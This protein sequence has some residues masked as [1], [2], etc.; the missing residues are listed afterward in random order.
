MMS[1]ASSDPT[2]PPATL[3]GLRPCGGPGTLLPNRR[4]KQHRGVHLEGPCSKLRPYSKP[5]FKLCPCFKQTPGFAPP[6]ADGRLC[7]PAAPT[8]R[9]STAGM[10]VS[11]AAH[12]HSLA[13]SRSLALSLAA[14]FPGRRRR[15]K[16]VAVK[17]LQVPPSTPPHH[18]HPFPC[19]QVYVRPNRA[20][21]TREVGGRRKK[22]LEGK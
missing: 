13:L 20:R 12:L 22:R 18:H 8:A 16:R 9:R 15:G 17:N 6:E 5:L 2:L 3:H 14:Q 10:P 19:A 4:G 21:E 7:R 1:V 11:P